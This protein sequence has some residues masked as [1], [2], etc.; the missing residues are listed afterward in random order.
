MVKHIFHEEGQQKYHEYFPWHC[1]YKIESQEDNIFFETDRII[2]LPKNHRE[3]QR[4]NIIQL[5]DLF[6]GLCKSI[7]HGVEESKSAKYRKELMDLI[8]PLFERMIKEPKTINSKYA[9][10]NRIMIR[11]FPKEKT[12]LYDL[13]RFLNQFYTKRKLYYVEQKSGQLLL[14]F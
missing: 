2:F 6:L 7:L 13:E 9:H 4:S 12:K 3:D 10:S 1:I 5:C 14:A 11:F 8:L